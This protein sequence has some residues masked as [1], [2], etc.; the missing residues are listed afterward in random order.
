MATD[1]E[2]GWRVK[3]L[4]TPVPSLMVEVARADKAVAA[5]QSPWRVWDST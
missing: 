1:M 3:E 2:A 4:V 5:L